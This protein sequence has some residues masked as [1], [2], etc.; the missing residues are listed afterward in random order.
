MTLARL[1]N[2]QGPLFAFGTF[3]N[4]LRF[5][6]CRYVPECVFWA[7]WFAQVLVK[8]AAEK[9]QTVQETVAKAWLVM[10]PLD[11]PPYECNEQFASPYFL[12]K[13]SQHLYFILK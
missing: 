3:S 1:R 10:G 4:D 7:G 8:E 13:F 9:L 11:Q 12:S 5:T 6:K 2:S